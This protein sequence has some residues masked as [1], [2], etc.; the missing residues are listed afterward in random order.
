MDE[1][2]ATE[3]ALLLAAGKL[4]GVVVKLGRET[5]RVRSLRHLL[6]VSALE[7]PIT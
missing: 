7:A 1:G 5:D 3:N 4:V 6:P 2:R